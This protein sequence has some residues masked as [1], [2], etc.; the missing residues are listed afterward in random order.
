MRGP[1]Y[2]RLPKHAFYMAPSI[3]GISTKRDTI[4]WLRSWSNKSPAQVLL[5]QQCSSANDPVLML[6]G[7]RGNSL[8]Q[9]QQEE[10]SARTGKR[11]GAALKMSAPGRFCCKTILS[12]P[13][14]KIDSRS[15]SKAQHR[16]KGACSRI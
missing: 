7:C 2:E 3:G 5:L 14:R 1:H 16:V 9:I 13:T 12:T 8:A 15:R 6:V 4:S 10:H 11:H